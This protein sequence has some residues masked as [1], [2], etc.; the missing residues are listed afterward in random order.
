M[1]DLAL[2]RNCDALGLVRHARTIAPRKVRCQ[3][4]DARNK[5][6]G[7]RLRRRRSDGGMI[8]VTRG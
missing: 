8:I 3:I 6:G 7:F 2:D 5:I 4:V 1:G